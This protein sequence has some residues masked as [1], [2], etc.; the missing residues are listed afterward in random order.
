M[1]CGLPAAGNR[2]G[3]DARR[4][5]GSDDATMSQLPTILVT[6]ASKHGSTREVADAVAS[7]LREHGWTV[8]L[9]EVA[10]VR[11]VHQYGGVVLGTALYMG[12]PHA[13][14]RTFLRHH[15][16]TLATMPLAVF[17]MGPGKDEDDQIAGSRKQLD[18]ALHRYDDIAPDVEAVFGGVFDPTILHFPFNHMPASDARDWNAIQRFADEVYQSFSSERSGRG[19]PVGRVEQR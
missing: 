3:R 19:D 12:R 11:D 2:D 9:R 18:R 5:P 4:A 1:P 13:D 8:D 14:A 10:A 7:R 16:R 17:A 6:Y 15:H